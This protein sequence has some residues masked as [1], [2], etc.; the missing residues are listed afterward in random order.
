MKPSIVAVLCSLSLGASAVS[1]AT[2]PTISVSSAAGPFINGAQVAIQGSTKNAA[3]VS[4]NPD[5]Q[6]QLGLTFAFV[7]T[8]GALS[9]DGVLNGTAGSYTYTLTARNTAGATATKTITIQVKNLP[10]ITFG[11]A[12]SRTYNF[13]MGAKIATIAPTVTNAASVS[14][15]PSLPSGLNFDTSN[16][17]ISGTPAVA[18]AAGSQLYTLTAS[19]DVG[20]A[21]ASITININPVDPPAPPPAP[22][23]PG[24]WYRLAIADFESSNA[25]VTAPVVIDGSGKVYQPSVPQPPDGNSSY[26][27]DIPLTNSDYSLIADPVINLD[28]PVASGLPL[29][30]W[31]VIRPPKGSKVGTFIAGNLGHQDDNGTSGYVSYTVAAT[32]SCPIDAVTNVKGGGNGFEDE[33]ADD[34]NPLDF[35]ASIHVID[36]STIGA[37]GQDVF[38]WSGTR[39]QTHS[40]SSPSRPPPRRPIYIQSSLHQQGSRSCA[41][42]V[43]TAAT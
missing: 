30:A 21:S 12:T 7:P 18:L 24:C 43:S 13:L 40:P 11:S 10:T 37:A 6:S 5:I 33:T 42:A 38:V 14:I 31:V 39:I 20:Q 19:N 4:I 22:T 17:K 25:G 1:A 28:N 2:A 27:Y 26:Y 16:G 29:G 15:S 32:V 35:Q 41:P 36:A 8:T 3:S 9:I 23:A 34:T